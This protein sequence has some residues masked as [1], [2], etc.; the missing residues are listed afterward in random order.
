MNCI[1][2][3]KQGVLVVITLIFSTV[4]QANE[5]QLN[6]SDSQLSFISIKK[7]HIA[8][9]HQFTKFDGYLESNGKFTLEI[10]LAS[11]DTNIAVRDERM[12]KHLFEIE[13]FA[14]ATISAEI[15][16]EIIDSIAQ[17]ASKQI[18]V[19]AVLN[20]HGQTQQLTLKMAVTRLV[21]AKLSVVSVQPV[22]VNTADFALVAGV[23][24][25]RKIAKLPS[26]SHAVPVSFYLTFNHR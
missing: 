9:T 24:K 17:G 26:I 1:K 11:V 3:L 8:E 2:T 25:L 12:K 19:N 13:T 16:M 4:I 15:D 7:T 22:I 6:T 5:W 21:S 20:L 18:I 14:T 10:D 23:E